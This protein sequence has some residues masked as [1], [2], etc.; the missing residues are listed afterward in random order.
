MEEQDWLT[1]QFEEEEVVEGIKLCAVVKAPGPYDYTMAFF[2][3]FWE[4]CED[5]LMQ[6]STT[7]ILNRFLKKVLVLHLALIQ[8]KVGAIEIRDL[9]PITLITG[10][11][12]IIAKVLTEIEEGD[13]QAS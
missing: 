2:Q 7:S 12:K 13:K 1:R 8:K 6:T 5:N 9:R 10:V 3:A 4:I 11:Y